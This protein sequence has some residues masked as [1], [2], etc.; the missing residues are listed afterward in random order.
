MCFAPYRSS[1]VAQVGLF[2]ISLL[3]LKVYRLRL[4][5]HY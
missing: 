3:L 1:I 2:N 5:V 4:S